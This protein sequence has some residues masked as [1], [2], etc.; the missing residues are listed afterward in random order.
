MLTPTPVSSATLPVLTGPAAHKAPPTAT[1]SASGLRIPAAYSL[2][3]P[4][5]A[6]PS[7]PS[8]PT[9]RPATMGPPTSSTSSGTASTTAQQSP[10][11]T[12]QQ[13]QQPI[14]RSAG[15]T[16]HATQG[17]LDRPSTTE[18]RQQIYIDNSG[19]RFTLP[20]TSEQTHVTTAPA[21][22]MTAPAPIMASQV[23]QQPA[24]HLRP[25]TTMRPAPTTPQQ[26][27]VAK[28][29]PPPLPPEFLRAERQSGYLQR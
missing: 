16:V 14:E 1:H 18:L 15:R 20:P 6:Q 10:Q 9:P 25:T 27:S 23:H 4:A 26:A 13:Q 8:V 2:P 12:Q 24:G 22:Y 7:S 3:A 17:Q 29:P 28:R 11:Q 19:N 21:I 5:K